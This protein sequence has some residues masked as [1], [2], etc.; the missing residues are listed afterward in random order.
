M[1]GSSTCQ[2]RLT[3]IADD[4]ANGGLARVGVAI[5]RFAEKMVE[6]AASITEA[7]VNHLREHG[8]TDPEVFDVAT[9]AA[10]RC[11]FSK[12]LDAMGA[13]P[14]AVYNTLEE[15]LRQRLIVGRQ[16]SDGEVEQLGSSA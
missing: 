1:T 4:F 6:D 16:I 3:L 11:F 10:A 2:T 8:L 15:P 12:L 14:D 13:E 9:A 7:D 5:M